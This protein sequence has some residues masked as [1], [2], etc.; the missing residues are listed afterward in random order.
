M[1]VFGPARAQRELESSHVQGAGEMS[2]RKARVVASVVL[3]VTPLMV[4]AQGPMPGVPQLPGRIELDRIA[5]EFRRDRTFDR[6]VLDL[7][8]DRRLQIDPQQGRNALD[9]VLNDE[10]QRSRGDRP[11]ELPSGLSFE[12]LGAALDRYRSDKSRTDVRLD[13]VDVAQSVKRMC[14][15]GAACATVTS[16]R[17]D[18]RKM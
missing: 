1:R 15:A 12:G 5:P 2:V 11:T 18:D 14:E 6:P 10:W 17:L 13:P 8:R 4:A 3:A 9:Q 7:E 16:G